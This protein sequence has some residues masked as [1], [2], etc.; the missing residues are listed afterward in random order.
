MHKLDLVL[1]I[2]LHSQIVAF[3]CYKYATPEW[4]QYCISNKQLSLNFIIHFIY[5]RWQ[6]IA[7]ICKGICNQ[8]CLNETLNVLLDT[9]WIL[10][11]VFHALS[12]YF[13]KM[14]FPFFTAFLV[15]LWSHF[16]V[17]YFVSVFLFLFLFHNTN[18]RTFKNKINVLRKRI[19]FIKMQ[20]RKTASL[21][22]SSIMSC[23]FKTS[24]L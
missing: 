18:K 21:I 23:T 10:L 6:F 8:D 20:S 3:I 13:V 12:V 19:L 7:H 5:Y 1:C 9:I 11:Y 22:H 24:V 4:R 15:I 2:L 14:H 16:F 17:N